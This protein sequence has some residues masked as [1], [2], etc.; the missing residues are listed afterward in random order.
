DIRSPRDANLFRINMAYRSVMGSNCPMQAVGGSTDAHGYLNLVTAG[1]LFT[2]SFG[3]PVNYHG[4]DE[5]APL[6][7]LENSGKILLQLLQQELQG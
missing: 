5:G 3:P 6:L 7:D 4:L 2:D 1:T